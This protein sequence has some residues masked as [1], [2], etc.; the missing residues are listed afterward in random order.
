[1]SKFAS[2]DHEKAIGLCDQHPADS[3]NKSSVSP[4]TGEF[5]DLVQ[6]ALSRSFIKLP[7][8]YLPVPIFQPAFADKGVK[9]PHSDACTMVMEGNSQSDGD[10]QP[11]SPRVYHEFAGRSIVSSNAKQ[12]AGSNETNCGT[13][14]STER[15]YLPGQIGHVDL[16]GAFD[17]AP[18]NN[19]EEA[20]QEHDD[21]DDPLSQGAEVR[22]EI[23]PESSRFQV[24]KTPATS[25]RVRNDRREPLE[26]GNTTPHLPLN[27][28]AGQMDDLNVMDASQA[29]KA[30]QAVSSPLVHVIHSDGIWER[31]SPDMHGVHGT[32]TTGSRSLPTTMTTSGTVRAAMEPQTTYISMQESQAKRDNRLRQAA[33]RQQSSTSVSSDDDFD[34]DD[35]QLRRRRLQRSIDLKAKGQFLGVTAPLRSR[36]S[37]RGRGQSRGKPRQHHQT[38]MTHHGFGKRAS[39]ALI[40]SDGLS[41]DENITED[42]TDQEVELPESVNGGIDELADENK[43][44]V[45]VP[46]TLR[47][48]YSRE[49]P[50]LSSQLSPSHR[51]QRNLGD[52]QSL[53]RVVTTD[54]VNN[55]HVVN[56]NPRIAPGTQTSTIADSQLS[57]NNGDLCQSS[58]FRI[59]E[60]KHSADPRIDIPQSPPSNA[61]EPSLPSNT[62]ISTSCFI[63]ASSGIIITHRS[64]SDSSP[65]VTKSRHVVGMI[66]KGQLPINPDSVPSSASGAAGYKIP[67][68]MVG[69]AIIHNGSISM[70]KCEPRGK[71]TPKELPHLVAA[72]EADAAENVSEPR[73]II[74]ASSPNEIPSSTLPSEIPET[75]SSIRRPINSNDTVLPAKIKSAGF[76]V[77]PGL[78][79]SASAPASNETAP[80]V[81]ANTRLTNSSRPLQA[82]S[83]SGQSSLPQKTFGQIVAHPSPLDP[84]GDIDVN[85]NLLSNEDVEFQNVING[86]SPIKPSK[87]RRRGN[88]GQVIAAVEVVQEPRLG[89]GP[90]AVPVSQSRP[91]MVLCLERNE[92]SHLRGPDR[93][94]SKAVEQDASAVDELADENLAVSAGI[95]AG[96]GIIPSNRRELEEP[97]P[98]ERKKNSPRGR[99]R[100]V[101]A[102]K[103]IS[104]G[105]S[106]SDNSDKAK[107]DDTGLAQSLS[108]R[109]HFSS[110]P[111]TINGMTNDNIIFAPNRVLAYFNGNCSAFYPA[112][113]IG[114]V[115][116]SEAKLKVRFDDG[117]IDTVNESKVKRLELRVGDLF[118]V[119]TIGSRTTTYVVQG[120]SDQCYPPAVEDPLAHSKSGRISSSGTDVYGNATVVAIAKKR[121][122]GDVCQSDGKLVSIPITNIYLTQGIWNNFKDRLYSFSSI[123]SPPFSR[124]QTPSETT[125]VSS[126]STS[127]DRRPTFSGNGNPR[128]TLKMPMM[129]K[130]LFKNM[131]FAVTNILHQIDRDRT[132]RLIV[133]NGGHVLADGFNELFDIP[134]LELI[135]SSTPSPKKHTTS[136]FGLTPEGQRIGFAC[137]IA[138]K[139]CRK[140]KYIQALAL[141]IPCLATRW[142]QDCVAAR[143][144][145][146][147]EPYLLS[148]GESS[149]LGGA[150]RSRTLPVYSPTDITLPSIIEHR[151]KLLADQSVLLIMSKAEEEIMKN[152][153]LFTHALG[154]S[155]V[156]RVTTL[157]AA[158]RVVTKAFVDGEPWD[159]LYTHVNEKQAEKVIFGSNSGGRKR[160]R[161]WD[162]EAEGEGAEEKRKTKVVGNEFVVQ[163]LILGRLVDMT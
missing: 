115:G 89:L 8:H 34:S 130:G 38:E 123:I 61:I 24:P 44:N 131:V 32:S 53:E 25:D 22:A 18:N 84:I 55:N 163:S 153:P 100:K 65:L 4:V 139:H 85:I 16:V 79:D 10:T 134:E 96:N 138:D 70:D 59:N 71:V 21:E 157:E 67:A 119:D 144:V 108:R 17:H 75:S 51:L 20:I 109:N 2:A 155:K 66:E 46:R 99:P 114:V 33:M 104:V 147:W 135:S 112:T 110:L 76:S 160:K 149:F 154:A 121:Q 72:I 58:K 95:T 30:T 158:A 28:F 69:D 64:N 141:G 47:K 156:S 140:A 120:F 49:A 81:S 48:P 19:H 35:S 5:D 7:E 11:L 77:V 117:T 146:P 136:S 14:E 162:T 29:F 152:H 106:P 88:S 26:R 23:Y 54:V 148:S 13:H 62:T 124:L 43:E 31:P 128:S 125:S 6:A 133:A 3:V 60:A 118:K 40:I 1:V 151:P 94:N 86:S 113:C 57:P 107:E 90:A 83:S 73:T 126:S 161:V 105:R 74:P 159:W 142:V 80:F 102:L 56:E 50:V 101:R 137:L 97:Q 129:G 116:G 145:L 12:P 68:E 36:P 41:G 111:G 92:A 143:Q 122:S 45:E 127:R 27:P 82:T 98:V 150:V 42:E 37:G 132:T 103:G 39:E 15:S 93:K 52:S 91:E 78:S 63:S 9:S 87:K